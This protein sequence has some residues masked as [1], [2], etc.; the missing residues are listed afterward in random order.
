MTSWLRQISDGLKPPITNLFRAYSASPVDCSGTI[1]SAGE[2]QEMMAARADRSGFWVQNLGEADLWI[3]ELGAATQGQPSI[4]I[5]AGALY[6]AP[7]HGVSV[8]PVSIIGGTAG[9]A[10]S[11]RE[12]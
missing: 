11:A 10:F 4:K 6:E 5:A 1:T 8:G 3:N 9:Q 7:A 12:W 2:A